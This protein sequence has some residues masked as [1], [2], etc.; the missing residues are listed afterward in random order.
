VLLEY[1]NPGFDYV[2]RST[3]N[4]FVLNV[5]TD[6]NTIPSAFQVILAVFKPQG[7]FGFDGM[8]LI[9]T[10]TANGSYF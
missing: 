7:S 3:G 4:S 5:K 9:A 10:V 6:F 1:S 8:T 2:V